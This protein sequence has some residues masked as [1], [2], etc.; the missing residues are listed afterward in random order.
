MTLGKEMILVV[1]DFP[2][3]L[4]GGWRDRARKAFFPE[5]MVGLIGEYYEKEIPRFCLCAREYIQCLN[6][7]NGCVPNG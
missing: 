4:S 6:R 1:K 7:W 5:K 3:A 2:D